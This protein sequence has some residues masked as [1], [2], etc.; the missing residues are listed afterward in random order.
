MNLIKKAKKL[1]LKESTTANIQTTGEGKSF[2][3]AHFDYWL[4]KIKREKSCPLHGKK[5][6]FECRTCARL[7]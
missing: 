3:K 2:L 5:N 4:K 1:A 6:N 7:V